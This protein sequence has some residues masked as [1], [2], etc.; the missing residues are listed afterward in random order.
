MVAGVEG[1]R[2]AAFIS[3][4]HKDAAAARKLHARLERYRIPK[5]L[6]GTAGDHGPVPARLTPIFRDRDELPAA[7]DLSET[8][9]AALARSDSLVVI[10]S[11][12][13]AVSEWVAREIAAF[14]ELHPERPVL[15]AVIAGEPGEC[16]PEGLGG[17]DAT[18]AAIEPLA[19]DLRKAGDGQRLG[20]LKLVAGLTGVGLDALVQRDAARAIRRVTAVTLTALAA[21]LVMAVLTVIALNA[22]QE[23]ERQRAEAEGMVEFMLTDLRTELRGVGRLEVLSIVNKRALEY[24]GKQPLEGLPADSLQRRARILHAIGE[25][26]ETQG[27]LD[28]ALARFQDAHRTTA[29]LLAAD[30]N[31][32]DRIFA[33]AQSEFWVGSIDYRLEHTDRALEAWTRYKALAERLIAIDPRNPKYVKEA[34]FAEGALCTVAMQRKPTDLKEALR[35]CGAALM[36]ME[37]AAKLTGD[38]SLDAD[39]LNRRMWL[40][41]AMAVAKDRAGEG[42]QLA[43]QES[44]LEGLI[45][46]DPKNQDHQDMWLVVQISVANREIADGKHAAAQVRLMKARDRAS[47]MV[48]DD[49]TNKQWAARLRSINRLLTKI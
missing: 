35:A 18:G 13:S 31:N 2:Y 12:H 28:R 4:S 11:P 26:E 38:N 46:R 39:L 44:L 29:A 30:P 10:C 22:R 9:R 7:G 1:A 40:G 27:Q 41:G 34:A 45:R 3:Y 48:R 33:H 23:A 14:R 17:I 24:Y 5:R 42:E 37:R 19:A 16:F 25:D 8:V 15:A 49:P 6:V 43:A 36:Q 47:A 20:F 21:T 32:P